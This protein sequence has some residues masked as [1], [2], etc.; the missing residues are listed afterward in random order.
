MKKII[1]MTLVCALLLGCVFAFA[2]CGK[3][4]NG[5]YVAD[6]TIASGTYEFKGNKVTI[7]GEILGFEKTSEATYKITEVEDNKYEITFTYEDGKTETMSFSDGEENGVKYI[8]L[9]GIKYN[10]Q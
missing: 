8:K 3:I 5:T 10:K 4:L 6:A 9:G 2:S 1:S 7:T